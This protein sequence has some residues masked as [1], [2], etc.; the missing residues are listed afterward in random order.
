MSDANT[1]QLLDE[2][3]ARIRRQTAPPYPREAMA[4]AIV[5]REKSSARRW[6][7]VRR[8]I[9]SRPLQLAAA[10]VTIGNYCRRLLAGIWLSGQWQHCLR[11]NPKAVIKTHSLAFGS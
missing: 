9:R 5:D 7:E 4:A 8:W 2:I 10:V 1:D 6:M 11:T 3:T